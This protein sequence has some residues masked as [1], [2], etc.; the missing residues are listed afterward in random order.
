MDILRGCGGQVNAAAKS[1]GHG[2]L[3]VLVIVVVRGRAALIV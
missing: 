3:G 1:A 2:T